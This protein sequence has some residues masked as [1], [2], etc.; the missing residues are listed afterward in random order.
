MLHFRV[1]ENIH[2]KL[3]NARV[4]CRSK[5]EITVGPGL[6]LRN[7]SCTLL[8]YNTD[9]KIASH[10]DRAA[11]IIPYCGGTFGLP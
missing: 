2:K 4:K 5:Y 6:H 9:Q 7:V 8:V 11:H 1:R 10:V 3:E